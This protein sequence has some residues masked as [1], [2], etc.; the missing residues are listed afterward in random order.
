[1]DLR[2]E[3]NGEYEAIHSCSNQTEASSNYSYQCMYWYCMYVCMYVCVCVCVCMNN[4]GYV[5][6]TGGKAHLGASDVIYGAC[7]YVC[8]YVLYVL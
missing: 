1:M 6:G 5:A 4:V 8:M 3:L 7:M 2:S